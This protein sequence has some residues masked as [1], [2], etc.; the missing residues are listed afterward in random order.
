RLPWHSPSRPAPLPRGG[1]GGEKGD[2]PSRQD[3]TGATKSLGGKGQSPFSTAAGEQA[4]SIV[5]S[6][7]R[8]H[9]ALSQ[10]RLIE[11]A[12]S[13]LCHAA[14]DRTAELLPWHGLPEVEKLSPVEA[15][16]RYLKHI[17]DAWNHKFPESP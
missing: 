3:R 17:H 14:V 16:A 5:G 15:S 12:K 10:G 1:E 11:S 13:W 6:F 7:A 2:S 4:C 8:D 9:G